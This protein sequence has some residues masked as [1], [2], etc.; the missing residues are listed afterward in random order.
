[1]QEPAPKIACVVSVGCGI[2]PAEKIGDFS[3]QRYLDMFIGK[4][5]FHLRK[6]KAGLAE[7]LKL[8]GAAV[9]VL[10]PLHQC[11]V[12]EQKEKG[13]GLGSLHTEF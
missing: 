9:C 2:Y 7:L 3:V 6:I 5:L 13:F 10:C 11:S 8:F 1:M 12:C 4:Q